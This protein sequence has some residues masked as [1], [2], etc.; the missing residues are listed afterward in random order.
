MT[1]PTHQLPPV[2]ALASL[3]RR[4]QIAYAI[5]CALRAEPL[6]AERD[7][8]P[9]RAQYVR[10]CIDSAINYFSAQQFHNTYSAVRFNSFAADY[11]VQSAEFAAMASEEAYNEENDQD[12]DA[13]M[14]EYDESTAAHRVECAASFS[15]LA[16]YDTHLPVEEARRTERIALSATLADY[17][18][19]VTNDIGQDL[20]EIGP[21]WQNELLD[22]FARRLQI[23]EA[24]LNTAS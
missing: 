22:S 5:R 18:W 21:L 24:L 10:A 2:E 11:G 14:A 3:P 15:L 23:H 20:D 12:Y 17:N 1:A 4:A 19:L 9:L 13:E 7:A 6:Y 16:T 8:N